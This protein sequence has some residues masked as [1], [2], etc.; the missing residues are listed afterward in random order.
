MVEDVLSERNKNVVHHYI[1]AWREYRKLRQYQLAELVG[2]SNSWMA[3]IENGTINYTQETLEDLARALDTQ[4]ARLLD[5]DP[6]TDNGIMSI[7]NR[8]PADERPRARAVLDAFAHA[9]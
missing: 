6:S 8:I 5:T 3:G 1:R 2:K 9:K 4:P 7:W